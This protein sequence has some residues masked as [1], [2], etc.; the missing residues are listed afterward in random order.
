MDYREIIDLSHLLVHDEEARLFQVQPQL[1][2]F[3]PRLSDKS[4]APRVRRVGLEEIG[5]DRT[6]QGY[7]VLMHELFFHTN[8][9]TH[10]E[11]PRHCFKDGA[12]VAD[13]PLESL[14][15]EA[16][17]LDFRGFEPGS[18]I[19]LEEV[20]EAARASGGIRSGDMVFGMFGYDAFYKT[21]KYRMCPHFSADAIAWLVDKEMTLMGI[22]GP[23]IDAPEATHPVN[24]LPLFAAGIPLIENLANLRRIGKP[25][26]DVFVL[27]VRIKY[28]DAFPVRVIAVK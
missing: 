21:E 25:R 11:V 24:H 17:V 20:R 1:V 28:L 13:F 15:G 27:P 16:V 14:V 9:G 5:K 4:A 7:Y 12:D 22:D 2:D 3:T 23:E 19:S 26:V 8:A 10:I 18:E 6:P